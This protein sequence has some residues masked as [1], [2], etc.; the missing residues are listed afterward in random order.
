MNVEK[1]FK[2]VIITGLIAIM[3]FC[4]YLLYGLHVADNG[5]KEEVLSFE[6]AFNIEHQDTSIS[7][8]L[9]NVEG[10]LYIPSIDVK[11]PIYTGTDEAALVN[12]V[13]IIE[14]TGDINTVGGN[15]VL[16]AHNGLNNSTLLMNLDKM[17]IKDTFFTRNKDGAI[18]KYE[19]IG[20]KVVDPAEEFE[21][22][23]QPD[24]NKSLMTLRT[25]TP[26]FVN[27][28]R[29]LVTGRE[30]EFVE[31]KIPEPTSTT[32]IYQKILISIFCAAL[33][34]FIYIIR[35]EVKQKRC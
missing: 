2:G 28:H 33:I 31:D 22:F 19:V 7:E 5:V 30:V 21:A 23:L 10:V 14:G 13:G 25:C 26:T 34:A 8:S 24:E 16:T 32:S 3:I 6:N 9:L 1:L 20:K 12:G 35:R 15:P 18:R 27:S 17:Q 11:L 4:S 29:L